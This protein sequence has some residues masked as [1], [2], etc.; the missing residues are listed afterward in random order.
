MG[1]VEMYKGETR[2]ITVEI[3]SCDGEPFTIRTPTYKL[4]YGD[5]VEAEGIPVLRD[6]EMTITLAPLNSGR[7]TLEC[8]MNI[9]NE[10]I[11]RR[12]PIFVRD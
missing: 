3:E 7:Y 5:V 2:L 4:K 12:L 10:V 9:A 1:S 11:I 8:T 6:H